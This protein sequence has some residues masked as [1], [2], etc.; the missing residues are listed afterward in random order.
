MSRDQ[1]EGNE[2]A[3]YNPEDI[4]EVPDEDENDSYDQRTE[5][6]F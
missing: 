5:A 6:D 4:E 3:N 2:S 1:Y